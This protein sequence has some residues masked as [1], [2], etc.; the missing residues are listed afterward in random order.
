M[1]INKIL[2]LLHWLAFHQRRT[3]IEILRVVSSISVSITYT[4]V[5]HLFSFQWN[6]TWN[7]YFCGLRQDFSQICYVHPLIALS[8]IVDMLQSTPEK[9][10]TVFWSVLMFISGAPYYQVCIRRR[11]ATLFTCEG[12]DFASK[13]T[14]CAKFVPFLGSTCNWDFL[15]LLIATYR[16]LVRFQYLVQPT[17]QWSLLDQL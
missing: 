8:Y 1:R 5:M 12:S 10:N 11:N 13:L 3:I 2:L 9:R 15:F 14:S 6:N 7:C 17:N 4:S 16:L